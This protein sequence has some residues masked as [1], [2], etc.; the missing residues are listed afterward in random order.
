MLSCFVVLSSFCF[1]FDLGK[2]LLRN[3]FVLG[4]CLVVFFILL[5]IVL[6]ECWLGDVVGRFVYINVENILK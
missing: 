5:S 2:I 1:D 3:F 4:Y 6:I